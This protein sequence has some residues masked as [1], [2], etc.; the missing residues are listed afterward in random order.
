MVALGD[1]GNARDNPIWLAVAMAH[2]RHREWGV[3]GGRLSI[4][5][6]RV[7]DTDTSHIFKNHRLPLFLP[8][9]F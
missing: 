4:T 7:G 5:S 6:W 9:Y 2:E 8:A 3:I 1:S